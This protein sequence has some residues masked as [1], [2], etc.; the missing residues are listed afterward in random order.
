MRLSS[1]EVT[2]PPRRWLVG[3]AYGRSAIS[4]TVVLEPSCGDGIFLIAALD[5]FVGLGADPPRGLWR[6]LQ[7]VEVNPEAADTAGRRLSERLGQMG[8]EIVHAGDFF[9]AWQ[10]LKDRAFD[11]VVGNP[12]FHSLS[13]FSRA[14]PGPSDGNYARARSQTEPS[15]ECLGPLCSR[16][17]RQPPARRSNG[18]SSAC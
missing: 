9:E 1:G 2:T 12:P 16:R 8:Q 10:E 18:V 11:A 15:D 13:E 17:H 14:I 6:Q 5:R 3:C 4:T 7:G